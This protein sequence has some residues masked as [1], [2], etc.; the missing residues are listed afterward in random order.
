[1]VA[2]HPTGHPPV[3]RPSPGGRLRYVI[4]ATNV[5][6]EEYHPYGTTAWWT[7]PGSTVS[8]KRY[9]HT[10]KEKDEESGLYYHGARYYAPWLGRW[11]TP[12]PLG[13]VADLNRYAYVHDRPTRHV[14]PSGYGD[15]DPP[16]KSEGDESDPWVSDANLY[17]AGS[18]VVDYAGGVIAQ[19]GGA[20]NP[21]GDLV[22]I[23]LDAGSE[24]LWGRGKELN[25]GEA[26]AGYWTTTGGLLT[27][28]AFLSPGPTELAA[29]SGFAFKGAGQVLDSVVGAAMSKGRKYIAPMNAGGL[30]RDAQW[31]MDILTN[32]MRVGKNEYAEVKVIVASPDDVAFRSDPSAGA[33]QEALAYYMAELEIHDPSELV[34]PRQLLMAGG[35]SFLIRLNARIM[36]SDVSIKAALQ[37]DMTEIRLWSD[38]LKKLDAAGITEITMGEFKRKMDVFHNFAVA[39]E[40]RVAVALGATEIK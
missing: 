14:D 36:E 24:Y 11:A 2:A 34:D 20:I 22:A 25:E 27:A 29:V 37:H 23:V 16:L 9:R 18:A 17:G 26:R 12:D 15:E 19:S 4:Q 13:A 40:H 5:S 8:Q 10:G 33:P 1:M 39:E 28:D 21:A 3:R 38:Y 32:V 6:Y 7:D 35:D 31:A 30:I